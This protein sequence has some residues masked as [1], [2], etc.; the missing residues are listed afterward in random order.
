MKKLSLC[1]IMLTFFVS[2]FAETSIDRGYL[3]LEGPEKWNDSYVI[4]TLT[5]DNSKGGASNTIFLDGSYNKVLSR[6]EYDSKDWFKFRKD[7]QEIWHKLGYITYGDWDETLKKVYQLDDFTSKAD[8]SLINKD[9]VNI[10]KN[11]LS[12]MEKNLL[13]SYNNTLNNYNKL[14]S[15]EKSILQSNWTSSGI[16]VEWT[17]F[18]DSRDGYFTFEIFIKELDEHFNFRI[19]NYTEVYFNKVDKET[20]ET[21]NN[22]DSKVL[23]ICS[24]I[25]INKTIVFGVLKSKS[26]NPYKSCGFVLIK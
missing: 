12:L 8:D 22:L 20:K 16:E 26:L 21:Y 7:C 11:T 13:E 3:K 5:T 9:A 17:R 18:V 19:D 14:S 4:F 1:V 15:K 25:S 24:E 10:I 2:L 6:F 23:A